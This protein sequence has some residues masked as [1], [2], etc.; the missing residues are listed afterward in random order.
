MGESGPFQVRP[1]GAHRGNRGKFAISIRPSRISPGFQRSMP[2]Y[3]A[4][5]RFGVPW[6]HPPSGMTTNFDPKSFLSA[7]FCRKVGPLLRSDLLLLG[8]DGRRNTV[9]R[10][11]FVRHR[12]PNWG[13]SIAGPPPTFGWDWKRALPRVLQATPGMPQSGRSV[14]P[15]TS[16]AL[17]ACLARSQG[18]A[19]PADLAGGG[20]S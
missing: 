9:P 2:E 8:V 14:R 12:A 11:G 19:S 15:A 4:L 3:R 6:G 18:R 20:S 7:L 17:T 16:P 13:E 5:T 10:P 1:G